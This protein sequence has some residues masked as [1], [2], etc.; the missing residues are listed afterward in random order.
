[1]QKNLK[2]KRDKARLD[3]DK[4]GG[5]MPMF[6]GQGA[7]EICCLSGERDGDPCRSKNT[8]ASMC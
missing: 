7:R 3:S 5:I 6:E 1:M 4:P 8:G 2:W